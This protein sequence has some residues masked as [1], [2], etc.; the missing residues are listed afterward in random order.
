MVLLDERSFRDIPAVAPCLDE[1]GVVDPLPAAAFTDAPSSLRAL[2]PFVGLPDALPAG[3][4]DTINDP[5][6]T[7]LGHEQKQYF[8]DWLKSSDATWKV[9]V[10]PVPIQ[11]LLLAP[12][13]RWEGYAS[14]RR[15]VLQFIRDNAIRNVV[16]VTTDFH[17]NIF[18]AVRVDP[19]TDAEPLAYEA[20]AGPIATNT[21]RDDIA[22]EVG[23]AAASAA[24][25]LLKDLI[26]VDCAQ[27]VSAEAQLVRLGITLP[28]VAK[29][30]W[31]YVPCVRTGNLVFVSGQIGTEHGRVLHPG[32]LGRDI[33][34][35]HGREA[36]RAC[37]I[38]ALAVLD[39]RERCVGPVARR[40]W[41]GRAG[42]PRR[43][44]RGRTTAR[45]ER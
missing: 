33:D 10:N 43:R 22:N 5:A 1:D 3:C 29:P 24:D 38:S 21:F 11:A 16:F 8:L 20:I 42:S 17:S 27:I 4:Q 25:G 15:E 31:A 28:E 39:R 37:A 32:K 30:R 35:A 45:R 14:E 23:D 40:V 13:D 34:V 44:R 19:F 41:G 26:K 6:R 2:R 36:A 18:G 12:Y 7:L 9:V